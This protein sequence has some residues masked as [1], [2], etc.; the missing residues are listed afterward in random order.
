M[1]NY[2]FVFLSILV[3]LSISS[4]YPNKTKLLIHENKPPNRTVA[5]ATTIP[6]KAVVCGCAPG[7]ELRKALTEKP[8]NAAKNTEKIKPIAHNVFASILILPPI[9]VNIY[10]LLPFLIF[11]LFIIV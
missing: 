10:L 8:K 7:S 11:S 5:I 3:T 4:P 9:F 2:D 1:D 6:N